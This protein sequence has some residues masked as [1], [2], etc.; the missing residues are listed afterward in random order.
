MAGM[1]VSGRCT[2]RCQ[3]DVRSRDA[4]FHS[5]RV[6]RLGAITTDEMPSIAEAFNAELEK[7]KR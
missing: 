4:T 1:I 5:R 7:M 2:S 3:K 6:G